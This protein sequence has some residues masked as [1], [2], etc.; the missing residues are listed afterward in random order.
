[1]PIL[2]R[3][4]GPVEVVV[5]RCPTPVPGRNARALLVALVLGV[6]HAVP[7]D[8]LE[9]AVWGEQ[10]P[11]SV[12]N[13]LQTHVSTLRALLGKGRIEFEDDAYILRVSPGM[14]DSVRF[15]RLVVDGRAVLAVEPE[16]S[17]RLTMDALGLWRGRPYG[18][19]ADDPFVQP[20]ARRLDEMRLEAMGL[21]LEADI[22]LG[23]YALAA[24]ILAGAVEDHPYH[25][26]LWY[27]LMT[28][29]A[30]DGRRV[31][32]LR[33]YRR[34]RE[35]LAEVGL[36][37][38]ADLRELEQ[39]ILIEAPDLRAHLVSEAPDRAWHQRAGPQRP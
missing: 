12:R 15:E 29:L 3:V 20:E 17:R 38:S 14:I 16:R 37:P 25:E 27:L 28:A 7:V 36:E 39:Q 6:D 35:H 2:I 31:E 26:R 9:A 32:A 5:G 22:A 13:T 24:G 8:H 23:R 33:A 4:L 19:L 34:L 30:R 10:P 18:D 11:L 21:R 1:M